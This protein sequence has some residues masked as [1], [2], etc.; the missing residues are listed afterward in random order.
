MEVKIPLSKEVIIDN[1]ILKIKAVKNPS[2]DIPETNFAASKITKALITKE[3]SPK[4]MIVSG[5]PKIFKI[6][7]TIRFKTP[8]TMAKIIAP[9]KPSK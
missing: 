3:K 9:L 4:V 5:N 1:K 7:V 2:I 8:K 6:G